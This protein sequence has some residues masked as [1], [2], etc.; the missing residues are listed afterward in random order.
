M[1]YDFIIV[2][3][4]SAGSLVA[5]RLSANGKTRVLVLEAGGEDRNFWLRLPVGFF[6]SMV[7]ARF[8]RNFETE[9]SEGTAGRQITWPRGRVIGGSSSI[10]GLIFIRGQHEDFDDWEKLGASGWGY[11]DVLPH[12]RRLEGYNGGEDQFRGALGELQVSRLRNDNSA[13]N[14]WVAAACESGLP[15]NSDFNGQSTYGVGSYQLSIDGHWR[16]SSA[17]AFLKPARKRAN[18]TVQTHAHVAKVLFD[19]SRASGVEWLEH[20]TRKRANAACEV[21]LCAG[22]LQSPQLLQLSGIGPPKLL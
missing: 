14:A 11:R 2:G 7:D 19:G 20:G 17:R 3:S 18:L 9:A 5:N 22:A 21:I 1:D 16:S 13:C 4:G 8:A 15:A 6:R 10:N 12:F